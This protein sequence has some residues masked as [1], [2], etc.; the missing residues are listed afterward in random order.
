MRP[1]E[2]GSV[3]LAAPAGRARERGGGSVVL[4]THRS[5]GTYHGWAISQ[6]LPGFEFTPMLLGK[7][8]SFVVEGPERQLTVF[9]F[10]YPLLAS[11][12]DGALDEERL[13][14]DAVRTIQGAV[15]GDRL[16]SQRD[17]TFEYHAGRYIE[18]DHPAWW[19]PTA[20]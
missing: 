4:S 7:I 11:W 15:E 2:R 20:P 12:A 16:G 8:A 1:I 6:R 19:I 5:V 10:M 17:L 3:M 14:A 13:M 9:A 18:V